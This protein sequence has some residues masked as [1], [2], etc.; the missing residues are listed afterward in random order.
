MVNAADRHVKAAL[1][2]GFGNLQPNVAGANHHGAAGTRGEQSFYFC[3]I[4]EGPQLQHP[5]RV[6]AGPARRD[7]RGARGDQQFVVA[8]CGLHA[9]RSRA[10]T[11]DASTSMA[12]TS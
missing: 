1:E 8:Q 5:L 6:D 2:Q 7:A 3:R 11:L 9:L 10:V 12:V 4:V